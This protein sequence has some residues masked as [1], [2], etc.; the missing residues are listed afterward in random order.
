MCDSSS[1]PCTKTVMH[2]YI[3]AILIKDIDEEN[4]RRIMPDGDF[5]P[6]WVQG[7]ATNEQILGLINSG[8]LVYEVEGRF[9]NTGF[10][11]SGEI[12]HGGRTKEGTEITMEELEKR[13]A[14]VEEIIKKRAH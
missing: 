9:E 3:R 6:A 1:H 5:V 7:E 10:R 14:V 8:L 4:A 13:L 12:I 2:M 11:R